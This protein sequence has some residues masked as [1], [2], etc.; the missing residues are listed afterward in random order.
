MGL[1]YCETTSK[2]SKRKSK[3]KKGREIM[4]T[5][6]QDKTKVE[7]ELSISA[8]EWEAGVQSTYEKNKGKYNVEG[9]RK[10]HAPRKVIEKTYGDSIFFDDTVNY[11][12]E[13]TLDEVFDK[14]PEL[15][16]VAQPTTQFESFTLKD[17][18]KMKIIFE[19]IPPFELCKYVDVPIEIHSAEVTDEEVENSI[20]VLLNDNAKFEEVDRAI[21]VNDSVLIDYN[22]FLNGVEFDGGSAQNYPLE[23]GSHTFI[24][25]FE[26]QLVGHKKGD[27]VDVKA[28]FP[29]EYFNE[30]L[31]GQQAEFRVEIKAV[32]EKR[33]P[34]LDDKFIS[35]ATE[36]ETVEEYRKHLFA[37]IQT[38]KENQQKVEF[39]CRMRDY[40]IDNTK[41]EIP[42]IM[43]DNY[44]AYEVEGL[45]KSLEAYHLTLAD[46]IGF[47]GGGTEEEFVDRIKKNVERSTR[48]RQIYRKMIKEL[49]IT[50]S[51]EEL[52][53]ATKET[54]DQDEIVKKENELLLGKLR[55]FLWDNNKKVIVKD[56]EDNQKPKEE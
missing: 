6:K 11:F 55:D 12:L 22:G 41:I 19:T 7:V 39:D 15:E 10:G 25:N 52:E 16:P 5:L 9:F 8:D 24:D 45:K 56:D 14:Q 20:K 32:R 2:T 4:Y 23:I 36:Y 26:D 49:N 13:K 40:L 28:T 48:S 44:V 17:G 42:Q 27:V 21:K 34:T 51:K 1:I 50:V 37:H 53:E 43:I 54:T 38:M 33:V 47:T 35:N 3:T 46:Y 29:K 31:A 18:L 30:D